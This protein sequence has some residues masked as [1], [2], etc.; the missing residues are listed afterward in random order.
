MQSTSIKKQEGTIYN[1]P[2]PE[3]LWAV[4]RKDNGTIASVQPTRS[5]ARQEKSRY[6]RNP[7]NYRVVCYTLSLG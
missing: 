2:E 3:R 1:L 7:A 6:N 5:L 4:L